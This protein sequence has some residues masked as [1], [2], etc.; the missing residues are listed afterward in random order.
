MERDKHHGKILREV[1]LYVPIFFCMILLLLVSFSKSPLLFAE[2]VPRV[3]VDCTDRSSW[4]VDLYPHQSEVEIVIGNC[5]CFS[6]SDEA[7]KSLREAAYKVIRDIE[8][9]RKEGTPFDQYEHIKGHYDKVVKLSIDL[10]ETKNHEAY[11]YTA[12]QVKSY[13]EKS[14]P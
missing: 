13:L 8:K 5:Y 14:L 12:E 10:G 7:K 4:K 3:S 9:M 2:E 11:C 6:S 1:L